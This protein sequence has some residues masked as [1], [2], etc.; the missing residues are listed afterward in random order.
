M[1]LEKAYKTIRAEGAEVIAISVDN[2]S[3]TKLMAGLVSASYPVLSDEAHVVTEKYG[4]FNL[5]GDGVSAPG[6]YVITPDKRIRLGHVGQSIGD[7]VSARA[8]IN[9]LRELKGK[10][11]L[12]DGKPL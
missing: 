6:T 5:L 11:P 8:I 7:R 3:D 10:G 1:E 9:G 2:M 12:P 4:L